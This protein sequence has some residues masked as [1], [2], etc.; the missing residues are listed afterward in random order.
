MSRTYRKNA[1]YFMKFRGEV[2]SSYKDRTVKGK[3]RNY[4][5]YDWRTAWKNGDDL[6]GSARF[7]EIVLVGDSENYHRS[8]PKD[9]KAMCH[10]IDR[11][12]YKDA[13]RNNED[14]FIKSSFD[15]WDW[16]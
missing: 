6:T 15:P 8:P 16:D 1:R 4:K 9:W 10:R 13:L 5:E 14:A 3:A 7:F 11:R 2:Y 12:R